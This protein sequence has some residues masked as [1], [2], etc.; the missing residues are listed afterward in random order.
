MFQAQ[1]TDN[2][3]GVHGDLRYNV[4]SG[5]ENNT[6]YLDEVEGRLVLISSL[7]RETTD[8]YN[9]IL[10]VEDSAQGS[11]DVKFSNVTL[12]ISIEDVNDNPPVCSP[13][14]FAEEILEGKKKACGELSYEQVCDAGSRSIYM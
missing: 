11:P 8:H 4:V 3:T 7:D 9:I 1:V 14:L 12:Y 2:D 5:N 13:T 6:F 10:R